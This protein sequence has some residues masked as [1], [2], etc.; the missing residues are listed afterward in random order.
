MSG[1]FH[2]GLGSLSIIIIHHSRCNEVMM[3]TF[4]GLDA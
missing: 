4:M 3:W 1:I 2:Q